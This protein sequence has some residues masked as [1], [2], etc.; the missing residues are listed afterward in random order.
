MLAAWAQ[1]A[2]EAAGLLV[3]AEDL[4]E[5]LPY[6]AGCRRV[7]EEQALVTRG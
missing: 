5:D 6:P 2:A 1:L 3:A 4:A 7:T